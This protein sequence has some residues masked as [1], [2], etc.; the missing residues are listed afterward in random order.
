MITYKLSMMKW[1]DCQD[2]Y[3]FSYS[4]LGLYYGK[5]G[6][7]VLGEQCYRKVWNQ[8]RS[9]D[10]MSGYAFCGVV[11][12]AYDLI[13]L[14]NVQEA[15]EIC[16]CLWE[17]LT[18]GVADAQLFQP[19]INRFVSIFCYCLQCMGEDEKALD[20]LQM[21]FDRQLLK[22]SGLGDY[23]EL[24]YGSHLYEL[25]Q[26]HKICPAHRRKE[27]EKYLKNCEKNRNFK[28]MAAWQCAN[29][30]RVRYYVNKAGE[31]QRLCFSGKAV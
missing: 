2:L 7:V 31:D 9:T 28:N 1:A 17:K 6:R 4:V 23:M 18:G 11:Y 13:F 14:E 24:V 15:N 22:I 27:I 10:H 5:T 29:F 12:F 16:T 26:H 3:A 8:M 19:D 20:V 30:Y 25:L 21:G